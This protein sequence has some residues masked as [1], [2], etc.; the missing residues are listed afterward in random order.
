MSPSVSPIE[1]NWVITDCR[2]VLTCKKCYSGYKKYFKEINKTTE[3]KKEIGLMT[4]LIACLLI[5]GFDF[6]WWMYLVTMAV[7]VATR[8][9]KSEV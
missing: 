3:T 7:W 4:L 1:S 5:W 2:L 6:P 8:L 9:I